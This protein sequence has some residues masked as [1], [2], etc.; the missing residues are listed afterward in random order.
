M[1]ARPGDVDWLTLAD[2]AGRNAAALQADA[3]L[4]LSSG[5]D[6]RAYSLA[7][8]GLEELGK[9]YLC[10]T[11]AAE[12][13]EPE[14]VWR[15]IGH[16]GAKLEVAGQAA[17]LFAGA[18]P[19]T[20]VVAR[21]EEFVRKE[22]A[23]KFRGLYVDWEADKVAQPADVSA[24]AAAEVV[25]LLAELV[26][27]IADHD[28]SLLSANLAQVDLASFMERNAEVMQQ[29]M[30]Y[31]RTLDPAEAEARAARIAN[32]AVAALRQALGSAPS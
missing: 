3:A 25:S 15:K 20:D 23:T 26:L 2:A 10:L 31:L 7:V 19:T 21:L 1:S 22:S 28:L 29:L 5:R 30:D 6:A 9:Y 27:S 4:L 16:H 17:A 13:A 24:A 14:S 11:V 8:L 32:D 18:L 12:L